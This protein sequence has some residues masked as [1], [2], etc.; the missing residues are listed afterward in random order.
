MFSTVDTV[1]TW[2]PL[3]PG[4]MSPLTIAAGLS[5]DARGTVAGVGVS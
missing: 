4:L 1:I 5:G 2:A 3:W